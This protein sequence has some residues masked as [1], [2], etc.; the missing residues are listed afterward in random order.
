MNET[1]DLIFNRV[2]LRKFSDLPITKDEESLIVKSGLRAPTAGNLMLYSMIV[3][4]NKETLKKLS[5]S[6]DNQPFIASAKLAII[7]VVDYQRLYDYFEY[8]NIDQYCVDNNLS[9]EFPDLSG[10]LLGAEDA[11]IS[12]LLAF[13]IGLEIGQVIIVVV[14]LLI[15]L[16]ATKVLSIRKVQAERNGQDESIYQDTGNRTDC[17]YG[18]VHGIHANQKMASG[19]SRQG[20]VRGK[21]NLR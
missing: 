17:L 8:C 10:L 13:N 14:I 15:G 11:F 9:F 1:L 7:F 6:C 4:R 18:F 21:G 5:V 20:F 2:S 3:I 12:S 16:I 19:W